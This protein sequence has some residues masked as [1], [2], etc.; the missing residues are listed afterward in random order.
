MMEVFLRDTSLTTAENDID[1][2]FAFFENLLLKHSVE[3]PPKRL[4]SISVV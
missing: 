4:A 2:S 3:S 1:Q